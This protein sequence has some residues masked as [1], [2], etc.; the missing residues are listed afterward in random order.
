[1]FGKEAPR[2]WEKG[3]SVMPVV[4][5]KPI[6]L[7]WPQW[8]V[9]LPT[10]TEQLMWTTRYR[11]MGIGLIAG[12]QS[13]IV[14][15]DIDTDDETLIAAIELVLPPSPWVRKGRRGKMLAYK[16]TGQKTFSLKDA[17]RREIVALI[18]TGK[19][20]VLPPSIHPDTGKPYVSNVELL[21]VL[22]ELRE[23]P[24]GIEDIL[25]D[26]LAKRGI[27]TAKASG[28]ATV[29][30]WVSR[31][32]RDIELT[33]TAGAL[34][35]GIVKGELNLLSAID[36]MTAKIESFTEQVAGDAIGV[37]EGVEKVIRLLRKDVFEGGKTLPVGWDEGLTSEQRVELGIADFDE[38][39]RR[40]GFEEI[41]DYFDQDIDR[42][43]IRDNP[44]ETL[45]V[46]DRTMVRLARNP[47]LSAVEEH[48]IFS[49]ISTATAGKSVISAMR[50]RVSELRSGDVVGETHSQAALVIKKELEEYGEIRSHESHFWQWS[51]DHWQR[52]EENH[53]LRTIIERCNN[54]P[55]V[56]K[57]SDYQGV[58]RTFAELVKKPLRAEDAPH[59]VNFANG[60]LTE[61]L[62]LREHDPDFGAAYVFPYPYD[63]E[64]RDNCPLFMGMLE[65]YWGKHPDFEDK[66]RALRQAMAATVF[67]LAPSYQRVFCM[68]GEGSTGKTRIVKLMERLMPPHVVCEVPPEK[69]NEKFESTQLAGRLLNIAGELSGTHKISGK[70]FKMVIEGSRMQGQLKG[71]QIFSY[72]PKAAHWFASNHLPVVDE[73]DSGFER[74]WLFFEFTEKIS[75]QEDIKDFEN[76]ICMEEADAIMAWVV[77]GLVDLKAQGY[78]TLPASHHTVCADMMRKNDSVRSFIE[79]LVERNQLLHGAEKT[80]GT[81]PVDVLLFRYQVF[82]RSEAGARPVSLMVFIERMV[83]RGSQMGF[84]PER[85]TGTAITG[86][87]CLTLVDAKA[88]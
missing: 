82:C 62:V 61:D 11:D 48:A 42:P 52:M 70:T 51:G 28:K 74:R 45:R 23:L 76:I 68:K 58:L 38:T 16:W 2:Y 12:Q 69:F 7:D 15:I 32:G 78:Y 13:G 21:D 26:V 17:E 63:A 75:V 39:T 20:F 72:T 24:E 31:G 57:S 6:V 8:S 1:M 35:Y 19:Q 4:G 29:T 47:D 3:I 77:Q 71:K 55:S 25:Q 9:K 60:Y 83:E 33:R 36:L 18:S 64:K 87:K 43:G 5:K 30:K 14:G 73:P 66:K 40:F 67:G 81:T 84:Q 34:A 49:H 85:R 88:A 54:M 22:D 56:R 37:Q 46:V 41:L 86:F 80:Q 44:I 27:E 65:R 50:K 59:G 79:R 10:E 53:I